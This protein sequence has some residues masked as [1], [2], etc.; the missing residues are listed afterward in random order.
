VQPVG[1][2]HQV[3]KRGFELL[4]GAQ[5]VLL[6][7]LLLLPVLLAELLG[8][9]KGDGRLVHGRGD[10]VCLKV[11]YVYKQCKYLFVLFVIFL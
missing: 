6:P 9:G 4:E 7:L 11:Q 3:V 1:G 5:T 8:G 10:L 2:V